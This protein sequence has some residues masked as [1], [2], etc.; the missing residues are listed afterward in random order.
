MSW[1]AIV[2]AS[3]GPCA[4]KQPRQAQRR[5]DDDRHVHRGHPAD[6]VA[7]HD[8]GA[9]RQYQPAEAPAGV[10]A[11]ESCGVASS[12]AVPA[13]D[14]L[15]GSAAESPCRLRGVPVPPPPPPAT[16]AT[17]M[18]STPSFSYAVP[19]ARRTDRYPPVSPT[20]SPRPYQPPPSAISQVRPH[21][22]GHCAARSPAAT[23]YGMLPGVPRH[24][25]NI[26]PRLAAGT[27]VDG[28]SLILVGADGS[29]I[30]CAPLPTSAA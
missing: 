30:S 28:P 2:P 3:A 19:N 13:R 15:P 20:G 25:A 17:G 10:L 11:L 8:V 24:R 12:V 14:G 5:Q 18:M 16:R 4:G 29:R 7:R 22:R 23:E 26:L 6:L 21:R 9:R 27:S 1:P